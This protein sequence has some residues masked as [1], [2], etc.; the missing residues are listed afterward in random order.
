M[1]VRRNCLYHCWQPAT[2]AEDKAA[3]GDDAPARLPKD[4]L[5][6]FPMDPKPERVGDQV[7][8]VCMHEYTAMS[9]D[10][11]LTYYDEFLL[12]IPG[13]PATDVE[14][15][16]NSLEKKIQSIDKMWEVLS[17]SNEDSATKFFSSISV[18]YKLCEC[19]H[20]LI[21]FF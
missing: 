17:S 2:P 15:Y 20:P 10:I 5:G 21:P 6:S 8:C 11:N 7:R 13:Q 4:L 19:I 18:S 3:T 9:Y 14:T 12:H 16:M 1:H